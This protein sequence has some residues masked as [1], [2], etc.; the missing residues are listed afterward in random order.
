MSDEIELV[1]LR[2]V[3]VWEE[4][5]LGGTIYLRIPNETPSHSS[6]PGVRELMHDPATIN[7]L[8][9][10]TLMYAFKSKD[11]EFGIRNWVMRSKRAFDWQARYKE[12][13]QIA[14][15][16][17]KQS[18]DRSFKEYAKTNGTYTPALNFKDWCKHNKYFPL[19]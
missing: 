19:R 1:L 10:T 5:N 12:E 13:L 9:L 17:Y 4:C 18:H 6:V 2:N 3:A 8:N 14:Y 7:L 15:F 16:Q 11:F